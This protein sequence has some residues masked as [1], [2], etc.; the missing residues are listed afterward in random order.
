MHSLADGH[1]DIMASP[2]ETSLATAQEQLF[3]IETMLQRPHHP[4][5]HSADIKTMLTRP[6]LDNM[7]A[8]SDRPQV[9][10]R[11]TPRVS[12]EEVH[13]KKV[14]DFAER[15][16]SK[17]AGKHT[18]RTAYLDGLRGFAA[19]LVYILHNEVWARADMRERGAL[20]GAW[21]L[22]N[23]YAFT[24]FPGIRILFS[25]GHAAVPI[26]F[27]ISGYVLANKPLLKLQQGNVTSLAESLCSALFR[28]WLRLYIP[29]M[30]CTLLWATSWHVF[31][32]S[33]SLGGSRR[34]EKTLLDEIWMWYCDFKNFSFLF[35]D[36]YDNAY[37]ANMWTIPLEFRGS[38][39]VWSSILALAQCSTT[40][41]L[42]C[43][44]GLAWYFMYVVDA[45]YCSLFLAGALLCDIDLLTLNGQLP[46]VLARWLKLD[47]KWVLWLMF[48]AGLWLASVPSLDQEAEMLRKQPGWYYLSFLKP[49]AAW[50]IRNFFRS[51]A[52]ILLMISIP[53]LSILRTFFESDFCQY[54]GK[55]S[56]ALYLVHGPILWSVGDRVYAAVGRIQPHH[57]GLIPGWINV[58]RF[59]GV[60]LM[61]LEFNFLA[62]QLILLPLN[63]GTA[64]AVTTLVD[65]PGVD[66]VHALFLWARKDTLDEDESRLQKRHA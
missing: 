52:A 46:P 63:L 18:H 13:P 56:F 1:D 8:I 51:I 42:L 9:Y 40:K 27:V 64:E 55:I 35:N 45:W 61:G 54:L 43:E 5:S 24:S 20:E 11:W 58:F 4:R 3:E 31:G 10:S 37:N 28:R 25:G 33:S 50:D 57:I 65:G 32:I 48:A 30:V 44:L 60:G 62:A 59:P 12:D 2:S 49:Q 41:R 22:S 66:L 47:R 6:H 36:G 14:D 53:R 17:S 19:L 39:V 7:R 38:I 16:G 34:P 23:Y 29:V 26:F 21:G 15:A